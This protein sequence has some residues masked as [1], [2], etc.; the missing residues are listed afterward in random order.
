MLFNFQGSSKQLG[1]ATQDFSAIKSNLGRFG[2]QIT[3]IALLNYLHRDALF[4]S[5]VTDTLTQPSKIPFVNID[6]VLLEISFLA[7][8][9]FWVLMLSLCFDAA[10]DAIADAF[11]ISQ[12]DQTGL[13]F[14]G[15]IHDCFCH[16]T[17]NM[18][19]STML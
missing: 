14:V 2:G 5:F 11:A 16:D 18:H 15:Q 17:I 13:V 9:V 8:D 7:F 6:S 1:L 10:L 4:S 19:P 3:L 12:H